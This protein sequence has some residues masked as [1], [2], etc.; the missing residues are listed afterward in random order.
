M[1]E[2]HCGSAP[3]SG[4]LCAGRSRADAFS[5]GGGYRPGGW[6]AGGDSGV[7]DAGRHGYRGRPARGGKWFDSHRD[8][9][10]RC[11]VAAPFDGGY[12][13]GS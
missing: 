3:G 9:R 13:T 1:A 10:H 4:V 2:R 8:N 7:P 12:R 11:G 6:F 5:L